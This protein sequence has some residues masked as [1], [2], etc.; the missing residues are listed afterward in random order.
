MPL[1]RKQNTQ[2]ETTQKEAEGVQAGHE[3][4]YT[5]PREHALKGGM[6][7]HAWKGSK[8]DSKETSRRPTVVM[9]SDCSL[10]TLIQTSR[11]L[12]PNYTR[13]TQW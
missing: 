9:V 12:C 4:S 2:A 13:E 11:V 1:L 6:S 3:M 5:P 10:M 7:S 8:A